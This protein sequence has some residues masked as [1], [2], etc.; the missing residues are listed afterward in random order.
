MRHRGSTLLLLLLLRL[1]FKY[2]AFTIFLVPCLVHTQCGS[3][4]DSNKRSERRIR[5]LILVHT[6][7]IRSKHTQSRTCSR[8]LRQSVP[9]ISLLVWTRTR[10]IRYSYV[11]NI[12]QPHHHNQSINS[13][14]RPCSTTECN[15]LNSQRRHQILQLCTFKISTN[16]LLY[17]FKRRPV[18][19]Q[20]TKQLAQPPLHALTTL[21]VV[22]GTRY[23]WQPTNARPA[24]A[25]ADQLKRPVHALRQHRPQLSKTATSST[26][27]RTRSTPFQ[28]HESRNRAPPPLSTT[29]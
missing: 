1:V 11:Q 9:G 23:Q 21:L 16:Q 7:Y 10:S 24:H 27:R 22:I 18:R 3:T 8:A 6:Y 13:T 15:G 19:V 4:I 28:K 25:L 29:A 26:T 14:S 5:K 17:T 20:N 12:N 2:L